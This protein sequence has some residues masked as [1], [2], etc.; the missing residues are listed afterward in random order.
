[1]PPA[2]VP[3]K[4]QKW[5]EWIS[6]DIRHDVVG[7]Y[8]R[9]QMWCDVNE[10][11]QSNPSVS[12]LRSSFWSFHHENCAAA[13]AVA[14]RRQA[15]NRKDTC[16]LRRLLEE[17]ADFFSALLDTVD[18]RTN[19]RRCQH[20]HSFRNLQTTHAPPGRIAKAPLSVP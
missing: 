8:F 13:Q 15:D 7:M 20:Q 2:P 6:N 16:S 5:R 17:I 9:R 12:Q 4:V 3:Q 14:I 1:M 10:I 19:A 11:L 18:R